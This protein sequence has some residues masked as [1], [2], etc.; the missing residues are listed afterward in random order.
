MCWGRRGIQLVDENQRG[1]IAPV[2]YT[3]YSRVCAQW[4]VAQIDLFHHPAGLTL[5]V[6][7]GAD[8]LSDG[9]EE[10]Q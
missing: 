9:V 7:N 2:T 6:N 10:Y 3:Q 1:G 5:V 8:L 4:Q